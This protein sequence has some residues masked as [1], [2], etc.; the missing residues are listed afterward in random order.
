MNAVTNAW[1]Q[2]EIARAF[3][4]V[5]MLFALAGMILAVIFWDSFGIELFGPVILWCDKYILFH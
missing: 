2:E 1:I 5:L 4:R 3:V